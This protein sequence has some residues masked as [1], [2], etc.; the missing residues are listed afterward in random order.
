M[1]LDAGTV[2]ART[3]L[4]RLY[5][6]M[7]FDPDIGGCCGEIVVD[8]AQRSFFQPIVMSQHFEYTMANL[9]DKAFESTI[10][11]IGVLPGAFSAYRWAAIVGPPLNAYFKLEDK[12]A[13][14]HLSPTTANMYLGAFVE[15][16]DAV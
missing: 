5:S 4:L 9:L 15:R 12:D 1:L 11:Y 7:E 14:T 10:G 16:C 8:R 3:S 6:D 13:T 2:A